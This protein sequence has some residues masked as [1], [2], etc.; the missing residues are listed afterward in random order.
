[1]LTLWILS[2]EMHVVFLNNTPLYRMICPAVRWYLMERKYFL[3]QVSASRTTS[4][5]ATETGRLTEG[6]YVMLMII[7][8]GMTNNQTAKKR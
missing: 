8:H 4:N 2:Q 7:R 3:V 1:V 5:A 6:G